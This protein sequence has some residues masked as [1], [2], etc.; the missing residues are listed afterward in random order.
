MWPVAVNCIINF[1]KPNFRVPHTSDFHIFQFLLPYVPISQFTWHYFIFM[2]CIRIHVRVLHTNLWLLNKEC[3]QLSNEPMQSGY[4]TQQ[5]MDKWTGHYLARTTDSSCDIFIWIF[6]RIRKVYKA[7]GLKRYNLL[8]DID[9]CNTYND[10]HNLQSI[11][12]YLN[13]CF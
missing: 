12:K 4:G 3:S 5:V 6:L 1:L 10:V 9:Y 8:H 7:T 2:L 13:S 11:S